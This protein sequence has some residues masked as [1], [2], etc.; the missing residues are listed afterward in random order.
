MNE[1]ILSLIFIA[2][3]LVLYKSSEWVLRYSLILSRELRIS[4]LVFGFIIVALSTSL[5]ELMVAIFSAIFGEVGLSVG[6]LL[7]AN[8]F[9]L[10]VVVGISVLSYKLIPLTKKEEGDLIELLFLSTLVTL[11]IFQGEQLSRVHGIILLVLFGMLVSK[12][13]RGG[14][15]KREFYD[16]IKESKRK[17]V[18]LFIVSI[19]LL[20]MSSHLLVGSALEIANL[21]SLTATFIGMTVTSVGTTLPELSVQLRAIKNK[22]YGLA[23]GDLL[24]SCVINLT[25]ILGLLSIISPMKVETSSLLTLLPFLFIAIFVVWYAISYKK[26]ITRFEGLI[27]IFLY[28]LFILEVFGII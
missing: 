10:T 19:L 15:I 21:F 5:S 18:I 1:L 20:L 27:L 23:M 6:N 9:N 4:T 2:S 13:Y 24:G 11:L 3:S 26:K 16:T 25:L 14:R 8:F 22:E 17:L 12:L 28:I 7:G